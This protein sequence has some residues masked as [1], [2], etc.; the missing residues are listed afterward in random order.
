MVTKVFKSGNSL[1]LRLPKELKAKPGEMKILQ[2]GERWIV[3]PI[4][5]REWPAG[6][7]ESIQLEEP[8]KFERPPQG[9]H[10]EIDL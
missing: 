3:T 5:P 8:E 9:E 1:A 2:E 7:F 4:K 10:R 6:F